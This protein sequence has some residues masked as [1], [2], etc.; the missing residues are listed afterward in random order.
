ME[1]C[2]LQWNV[3]CS[4][5][6]SKKRKKKEGNNGA[7]NKKIEERIGCITPFLTRGVV[8]ANAEILSQIVIFEGAV[9]CLFLTQNL[10][11]LSAE[12]YENC[13]VRFPAISSGEIIA[14]I[15]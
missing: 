8:G 10:F 14:H 15:C 4:E 3:D 9:I 5:A 1:K 11:F 2:Q 6:K 12:F 13:L 7:R